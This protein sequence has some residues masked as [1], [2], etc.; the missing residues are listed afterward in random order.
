[1]PLGT[2]LAAKLLHAERDRSMPGLAL[3]AD[4]DVVTLSYT[5]AVGHKLA[6]QSSTSDAIYRTPMLIASAP[7]EQRGVFYEAIG[8]N[9]E[10]TAYVH[11][12]EVIPSRVTLMSSFPIYRAQR[13]GV[14]VPPGGLPQTV[15]SSD[16]RQRWKAATSAMGSLSPICI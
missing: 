3:N 14:Q 6:G 12:F 2:W 7:A 13:N 11:S 5:I 9:G 10:S 4:D 15:S 1:M 8:L 16:L